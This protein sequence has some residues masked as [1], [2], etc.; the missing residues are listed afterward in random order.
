[1]I[2]LCA[3]FGEL[4]GFFLT[5]GEH[6][7]L[8]G[9]TLWNTLP[10]L[11]AIV[12]GIAAISATG[13]H[14]RLLPVTACLW[15]ISPAWVLYDILTM[16]K[17]HVFSDGGRFIAGTLVLTAADLARTVAALIL[18]IAVL[19]GARLGGWLAPRAL[20][21]AL[22]GSLLLGALG[23][24]IQ[25]FSS[26]LGP[27]YNGGYSG[28]AFIDAGYA[29][30]DSPNIVFAVA[31]LL[32]AVFVGCLGLALQD[33]ARG[34]GLVLGWSAMLLMQCIAY[35]TIPSYHF[36]HKAT[37]LVVVAGVCLGA[38]LLGSLAYLSHR[39]SPAT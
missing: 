12:V 13:R 35:A 5:P 31:A 36:T 37:V 28:G 4:L 1:M 27:H 15:L 16:V 11:A 18:L 30:G 38:S 6:F 10:Y 25:Y 17:Y 24:R 19:R 29:F 14:R 26:S 20:S 2:S 22:L 3:A 9:T 32:L 33:R 8:N 21:A 34:G 23:W 39:D 7:G